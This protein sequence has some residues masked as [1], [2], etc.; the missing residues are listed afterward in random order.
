MKFVELY[1]GAVILWTIFY[2]IGKILFEEKS[3]PNYVKILLTMAVFSASL[4]HINYVN[5]D[6][7]MKIICV[8]SLFCLFY[9][10]VFQK[11]LSNVLVASLIL[12]LCLCASEVLVAIAASIILIM[13]NQSL[14]FLKNTIFINIVIAYIQIL[15]IYALKSKLIPYVKNSKL[16]RRSSLII[17]SVLLVTL[18]LLIFRIPV[19]KWKFNTEFIITML[20][21]LFFCIMGLIMIKQNS[22]IQKTKMMYQNLVDYSDITNNLLEDYRLVSHERKNQLLVIRSMLDNSNKELVD[23]VDS[24]LDKNVGFKY[25][26]IGELNRLPLSGLKGLINYKLIEANSLNISTNISI[27]K[28]ITKSKLNKLSTNQKDAL[29]S[30]MGVYIDNA[31]QAAT[32]SKD[33]EISLEIYKEKRKIIIILANTYSG[34]VEL[35]KLDDYGYTT[36]GKN[37]GVGLHLVKRILEVESIYSQSRELFDKYYVQKLIINLEE[38]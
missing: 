19:N 24:L 29:Y 13:S 2:L 36:K 3:K 26:W 25:E 27:S 12:Y 32:N 34:K 37:H 20:I 15:M 1:I 11:E 7:V 4:A 22:D 9:K 8:Y 35:E 38:L 6:G 14:E 28:E 17:V 21:L 5:S 16:N 18:A 10:I 30:I 33:K 23:Y 31:I